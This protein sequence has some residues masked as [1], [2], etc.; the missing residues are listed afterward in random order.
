M[1]I[2]IA[3]NAPVHTRRSLWVAD[4]PQAPSA[5][6][7]FRPMHKPPMVSADL[8]YWAGRGRL[9]GAALGERTAAV[10]STTARLRVVSKCALSREPTKEKRAPRPIQ[11]AP[12]SV[13]PCWSV[14]ASP[15]C[16]SFYHKRA[17][18]RCSVSVVKPPFTQYISKGH[19]TRL[20]REE[21]FSG[22]RILR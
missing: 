17:A 7:Q 10:G 21:W 22:L 11:D 6:T 1:L 16:A 13:L 18:S 14:T 5:S 4:G 19:V 3:S 12:P 8:L 20:C 15:S 2:V 9:A